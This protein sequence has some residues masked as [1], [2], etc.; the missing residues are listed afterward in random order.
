MSHVWNAAGNAID[1]G[2]RDVKTNLIPENAYGT[3]LDIGAGQT[4]DIYIYNTPLTFSIVRRPR[5]HCQLS[6]A[7]E[8]VQV[9]RIGTKHSHAS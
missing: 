7:R 6:G 8:S 5:T 4:T 2:G 3:I 9:H 1:E